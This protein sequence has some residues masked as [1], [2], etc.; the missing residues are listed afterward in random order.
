MN[1]VVDVVC[2]FFGIKDY[3]V[4]IKNVKSQFHLLFYL[5]NNNGKVNHLY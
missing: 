4:N 3:I 1:G 5:K 2:V